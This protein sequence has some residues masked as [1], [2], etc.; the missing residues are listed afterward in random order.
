MFITLSLAKGMIRVLKNRLKNITQKD[1]IFVS[2]KYLEDKFTG[3]HSLYKPFGLDTNK[4]YLKN[5]LKK[6]NIEKEVRKSKNN[7]YKWV[8]HKWEKLYNLV[9]YNNQHGNNKNRSNKD[10]F[11]ERNFKAHCGFENN[12]TEV[13][14]I[15]VAL[16][17]NKIK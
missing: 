17:N 9:E 16:I 4:D 5:E 1:E 8:N 14:I 13:A 11:D 2:L 15:N 7:G 10:E 6:E 3:E 12:I